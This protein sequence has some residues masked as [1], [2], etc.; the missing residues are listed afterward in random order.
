MSLFYNRFVVKC[1]YAYAGGKGVAV[2][3]TVHYARHCG[4]VHLYVYLC[5]YICTVCID[6]HI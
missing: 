3:I 4:Q 2:Y 5:I 6:A 1:H